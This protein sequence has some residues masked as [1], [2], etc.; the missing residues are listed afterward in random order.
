LR[1]LAPVTTVSCYINVVMVT[2][3]LYGNHIPLLSNGHRIAAAPC[4]R[5]PPACQSLLPPTSTRPPQAKH[6][7]QHTDSTAR[8]KW[9]AVECGA[10]AARLGAA[11]PHPRTPHPGRCLVLATRP[12]GRSKERAHPWTLYSSSCR[13]VHAPATPFQLPLPPC[14]LRQLGQLENHDGTAWDLLLGS[15]GSVSDPTTA[16]YHAAAYGT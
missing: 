3:E 10:A 13:G 12:P 5:Q 11:A 8:S 15:V 16:H 6:K 9:P 14:G 7:T 1:E 2:I 4:A